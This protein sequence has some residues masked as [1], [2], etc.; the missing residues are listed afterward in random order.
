MRLE[1]FKIVSRHYSY[2]F[3]T[4]ARPFSI[5]KIDIS[6]DLMNIS[7]NLDKRSLKDFNLITMWNL[8]AG[9]YYINTWVMIKVIGTIFC[10]YKLKPFLSIL[11]KA[12]YKW[13]LIAK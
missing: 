9:I 10:L 8:L 5:L 13:L 1:R 11:E 2:I 6:S 4:K 3:I 7:V 12:P